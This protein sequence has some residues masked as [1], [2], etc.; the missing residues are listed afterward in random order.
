LFCTSLFIS[1]TIEKD[2]FSRQK[3]NKKAAKLERALSH[4]PAKSLRHNETE[5]IE[6]K[7][8][9]LFHPSGLNPFPF[10]SA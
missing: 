6:M 2:G 9:F 7:L 3:N 10:V 1:E 4:Q 8:I 5:K